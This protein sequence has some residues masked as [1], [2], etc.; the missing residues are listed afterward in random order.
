MGQHEYL[1]PVETTP[2]LRQV[3][4]E[5]MARCPVRLDTSPL[6]L[7]YFRLI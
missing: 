5:P 4:I 3:S 6:T 2:A 1:C 7:H